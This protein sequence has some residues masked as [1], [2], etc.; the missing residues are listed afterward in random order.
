MLFDLG[1]SSDQI[2]VAGNLLLNGVVRV[3]EGSGFGA[4][5]SYTLITYGGTL[6]DAGLALANPMAGYNYTIST[7][8]A[9]QVILLT[10][11]TALSFWDSGNPTANGVIEGG[12]GLWSNAPTDTNWTNGN[13]STPHAGWTPGQTAVFMGTAGNVGVA[14]TVVVGGL[15]FGSSYT[16]TD[17]GGN[18]G[19]ISVSAAATEVRVNPSVTA[20]LDVVVTG[21]GGL[22]KTS[23]GTLV[24]NKVNT[25]SGAT[26][27]REGTLKIGV[28]NAL[29]TNT[30]LTVGADGTAA[31]FDASSA[32]QTVS[33]LQVA[34]NSPSNS[35]ITV[36]SGE[37]LT[38]SGTGSL[39]IGI[40][41]TY[42]AK[43][44]A[45]FT[46]GGSLVVNNAS[47][48][49]E[50]G[51]QSNPSSIVGPGGEGAFDSAA[52]T[53]T[54]VTDMTG[55]GSFSATVNLFRVGFG[56]A[57][58][59]T[60][61]LSNGA[62]TINAN[63][64]QISDSNGINAGS[65]ASGMILGTGT[66]VL[67]TNLLTVGISK[68]SGYLRFAS[69]AAGSAG[70]VVIGGENWSHREHHCREHRGHQYRSHPEW[71]PRPSWACG[72]SH[73]RD[74]GH[75]EARYRRQWRGH[76]NGQL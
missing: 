31:N 54:T 47:G 24:L 50:A 73:R 49:F 13:D 36:G 3:T 75:R 43:T 64:I 48:I 37:T 26:V 55:L 41:N 1:T 19:K 14:D 23:G 66:N 22:S 53:N 6:A 57:N 29:P 35:T 62:N 70:T 20:T 69:Q 46:G 15:Q 74:T 12:D 44:N 17:V 32:S 18:A 58:S 76:G 51:I 45:I 28:D 21:S 68:A 27:V 7:A 8:T 56:V 33:S 60:L 39:K 11:Q 30:A 16:L 42:K 9:G 40:L 5:G 71:H 25:Y 61:S 59:S 67:E 38:V 72:H 2:T 65:S 52:N 4:T 10:D 34:S 63:T